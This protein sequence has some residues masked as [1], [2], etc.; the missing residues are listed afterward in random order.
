MSQFILTESDYSFQNNEIFLDKNYPDF[1]HLLNVFRIKENE[2]IK[3]LL[4]YKKDFLTKTLFTKCKEVKKNYLRFIV[5]KIVDNFKPKT[6]IN[7]YQCVPSFDK[8]DKIVEK[9][10]EL[11][12]NNICLV[13]SKNIS[14]NKNLILPK[15]KRL[16]KIIIASTKQSDSKFITKIKNIVNIT[17]LNFLDYKNNF[18]IVA[19]ENSMT[20]LTKNFR[21]KLNDFLEKNKNDENLKFNLLIGPEGG[22]NIDEINFLKKNNWYDFKLNGNILRVETAVLAMISILKY[23]IGI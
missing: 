23:E 2:N 19:Y 14:V 20:S 9:S 17:D 8:L 22:L 18:N 4:I 13:L 3:F 12:I 6:E 5:E 21:L 7:L 16:E 10:V 15:I 11:N 1:H